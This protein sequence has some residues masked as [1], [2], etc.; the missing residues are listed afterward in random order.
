MILNEET[1]YLF[2]FFQFYLWIVE[3]GL[4]FGHVGLRKCKIQNIAKFTFDTIPVKLIICS[5]LKLGWRL[6]S[7]WRLGYFLGFV[8][9]ILFNFLKTF[10]LSNKRG[11]VLRTPFAEVFEANGSSMMVYGAFFE[12][13]MTDVNFSNK[14]Y[15]NYKNDNFSKFECNLKP[16]G[17]L[18]SIV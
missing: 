5:G 14:H 4:N 7:L 9:C 12:I 18:I 1:S 15:K 13:C 17:N 2:R 3:I 10:F 8:V 16:L 6:V 11:R